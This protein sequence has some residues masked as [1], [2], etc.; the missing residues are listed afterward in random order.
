ML[1]TGPADE[2]FAIAGDKMPYAKRSPVGMWS[3]IVCAPCEQSFHADDEFLIR[4]VRNLPKLP[5]LNDSDGSAVGTVLKDYDAQEIKRS[6]LSVFFRAAL[7]EHEIFQQVKLGPYLEPLRRY[8][9]DGDVGAPQGMEIVLRHV[10]PPL[11][12][13]I[14]SPVRVRFGAVSAYRLY[15]PFLTAAIKVDNR[16]WE[17]GPFRAAQLTAGFTPIAL[18][19]ERPSPSEMRII[20]GI[21]TKHGRQIDRMFARYRDRYK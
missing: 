10:L 6:V 14:V 16:D 5:T 17:D 7:S 15:L 1:D 13:L 19:S 20:T 11:G 2:P 18:R 4:L 3:R 12:R 21:H 9:A 8:I